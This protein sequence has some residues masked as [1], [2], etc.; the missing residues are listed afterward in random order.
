MYDH[1]SQR[2]SYE[3]EIYTYAAMP[4]ESQGIDRSREF[5]GTQSLG[6][7]NLLR[8]HT[9]P[10]DVI[11]SRMADIIRASFIKSGHQKG[12]SWS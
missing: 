6:G 1:D 10:G 12:W 11:D 5:L 3:W 8:L 2:A 9:G 4:C 7:P